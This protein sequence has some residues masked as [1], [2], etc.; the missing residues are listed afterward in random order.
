MSLLPAA[1]RPGGEAS[2]TMVERVAVVE[3]ASAIQH[4]HVGAPAPS[5]VSLP[6]YLIRAVL[7]GQRHLIHGNRDLEPSA[8]KRLA[9]TARR[10]ADGRDLHLIRPC[11]DRRRQ[12][13]ELRSVV[14]SEAGM[15]YL[16]EAYTGWPLASIH[17]RSKERHRWQF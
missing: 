15:T 8:V 12:V 13:G 3:A 6:P 10:L 5:V 4:S 16:A 7:D 14:E 11:F 9:L 17:S 1:N 2:L